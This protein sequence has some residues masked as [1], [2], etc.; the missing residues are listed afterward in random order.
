VD[1]KN[2]VRTD[3]NRI[4]KVTLL[5][6][7]GAPHSDSAPAE[8]RPFAPLVK[9]LKAISR[10][11]YAIIYFSDFCIVPRNSDSTVFEHLTVTTDNKH[12]ECQCVINKDDFDKKCVSSV[13]AYC[14]HKNGNFF[15]LENVYLL[16]LKPCKFQLAIEGKI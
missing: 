13:S 9:P 14:A 7:F 6:Y 12:F 8:L 4:E 11:S 16:I 5:G 3:S 10:T 15:V 2:L 1:E